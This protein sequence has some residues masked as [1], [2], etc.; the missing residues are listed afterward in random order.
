MKRCFFF[1]LA[2]LV[3]CAGIDD[4]DSSK[5]SIITA[6]TIIPADY[7]L[8]ISSFD[9]NITLE[10]DNISKVKNAEFVLE[11][12]DKKSFLLGEIEYGNNGNISVDNAIITIYR[13]DLSSDENILL[14]RI[15]Y[16]NL[17]S[18]QNIYTTFQLF[19]NIFDKKGRYKIKAIIDESDDYS[20]Y[21]ES[22]NSKYLSK[23]EIEVI[24]DVE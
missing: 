9:F 4:S 2:L 15:S 10:N 12:K 16:S 8:F 14:K 18:G 21:L 13:T 6:T 23:G 5:T 3:S 11:P 22:N 7:D 1:F 20:E 17:T 24:F 19:A